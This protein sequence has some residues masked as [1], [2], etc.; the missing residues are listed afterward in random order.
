MRKGVPASLL[1][2]AVLLVFATGMAPQQDMYLS[3]GSDAPA[4]ELQAT[5]GVTYTLKNMTEKTPVFM[6]FWKGSCPHN[7]RAAPLFESLKNAY[8]DKV[9]LLGVVSTSAE[10]AKS[11]IDRYGANYP[12]MPDP[13]LSL[14]REYG[15][16][17]SI[18]TFQIGTDGKIV[19]VFPGYGVDSMISLNKAMAEVAG[20]D[21]AEVDLSSAPSRLTWG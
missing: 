3:E 21:A 9:T 20:V 1:A 12:L 6:V 11:W 10:G 14:I 8:G 7:P 2:A 15:L 17:K 4:F 18:C 19:K 5:D 13:D 16:S